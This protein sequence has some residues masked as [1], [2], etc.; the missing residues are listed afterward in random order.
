METGLDTFINA[1]ASSNYNFGTSLGQL[2]ELQARLLIFSDC[3]ESD[4]LLSRAKNIASVQLDCAGPNSVASQ[5]APLM[6]VRQ[7]VDDSARLGAS[8]PSAA[9][10]AL[11]ARLQGCREACD[12]RTHRKSNFMAMDF[13]TAEGLDAFQGIFNPNTVS[14]GG[15]L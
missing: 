7:F 14:T 4:M 15:R 6:M 11:P 1:S 3:E 2:I 9:A 12:G 5:A 10:L 13:V 8:P